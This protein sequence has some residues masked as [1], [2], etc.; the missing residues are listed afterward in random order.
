MPRSSNFFTD[1]HTHTLASSHAYSTI[2]EYAQYA[3]A[4][5]VR[6]FAVTDHGPAMPDSPSQWHFVNF[7]AL[8]RLL[9]G[10]LVLRGIEA[11][12]LENGLDLADMF[13]N[14]LDIVLAG[15]HVDCLQP[16]NREE[17]TR[18]LVSTMESGRV[19]IITHPGNPMFPINALTVAGAAS[20]LNVALEVNNS[21]F[22]QSHRRGSWD[23]CVELIR[24]QAEAGGFIALGSDS[25]HS[26]LLGDFQ[27]SLRVVDAA[28]FP[29]ERIINKTPDRV[30]NFLEKHGKK[31]ED[32][33]EALAQQ[34]K[35]LGALP[36]DIAVSS[37]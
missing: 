9:Y 15:F 26:H 11:N 18:I 4:E 28:G 25:H 29:E 31:L 16:M 12:I 14:R 1:L 8:P 36:P 6:L 13:L 24:A 17:N 37:S 7:E 3:A 35:A 22:R 34:E 30:L 27:E 5:G 2:N 21:S 10:V 23:N 33:R 32:V 20:R 19:Q